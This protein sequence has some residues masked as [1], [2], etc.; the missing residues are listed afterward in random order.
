MQFWMSMANNRLAPKST[1]GGGGDDSRRSS[2]SSIG[3]ASNHKPH[4]MAAGAPCSIVF[5]SPTPTPNASVAL[6]DE[7]LY[8]E[9]S[10]S[11]S[12][13]AGQRRP[14]D[15]GKYLSPT[16]NVTSSSSTTSR[17][18]TA[19]KNSSSS[20]LPLDESNRGRRHS[21][22]MHHSPGGVGE[23]RKKGRGVSDSW[24]PLAELLGAGV[25]RS[26]SSSTVRSQKSAYGSDLH[27]GSSVTFCQATLPGAPLSRND[28][29]RRSCSAMWAS[30]SEMYH[31]CS[32]TAN[33][34]LRGPPGA[35]VTNEKTS[36][37]RWYFYTA[38]TCTGTWLVFVTKLL[39]CSLLSSIER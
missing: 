31:R 6:T 21:T 28:E 39:S 38:A 14:S 8:R 9:R 7:Q 22:S 16:H 17:R 20:L 3:S 24:T 33:S 29:L 12:E 23:E 26:N 11:A 5:S 27:L 18:I 19:R 15:V 36:W 30:P 37:V 32:V 4:K 25:K 10:S 2:H 35:Q 13:T 1:A 34:Y